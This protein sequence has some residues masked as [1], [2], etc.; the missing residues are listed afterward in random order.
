VL[1]LIADLLS[2]ISD[3]KCHVSRHGGE[4]FVMLFRGCTLTEAKERLDRLRE[5]LAERRLV[6]RHNDEP[7]GQITFSAG[8]ADVFDHPDPRAALKAA[9][10]ALYGAKT[11]GR[12]QIRVAPKPG[13]AR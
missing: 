1:R 9:H 12:N 13:T 8:V 3:D 2:G 6:N 5:S 4:E 7:F 10:E 11:G